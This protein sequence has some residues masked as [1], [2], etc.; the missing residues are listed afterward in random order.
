MSDRYEE[1]LLDAKRREEAAIFGA[2]DEA[3]EDA[4]ERVYKARS[5]NDGVAFY[6]LEQIAITLG[7]AKKSIATI[8]T[9]R[10]KE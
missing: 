5:R 10:T 9:G 2:M 4:R 3:F 6:V 8:P 1:G 7:D